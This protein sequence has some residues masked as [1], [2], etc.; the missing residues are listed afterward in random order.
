MLQYKDNTILSE[1]KD[2][3]SIFGFIE[4]PAT[5]RKAIEDYKCAQ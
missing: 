2:I 5:F 4:S 3:F 1:I